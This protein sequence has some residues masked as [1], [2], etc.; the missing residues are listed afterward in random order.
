M[1]Y[2]PLN[3]FAQ[4]TDRTASQHPIEQSGRTRIDAGR[5][6][7]LQSENV[8]TLKMMKV[9]QFRSLMKGQVFKNSLEDLVLII[10]KSFKSELPSRLQSFE[11]DWRVSL[12]G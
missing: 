3:S 4:L 8:E 7:K 1:Y 9:F 10:F 5:L 6:I 11:F 2:I 12:V